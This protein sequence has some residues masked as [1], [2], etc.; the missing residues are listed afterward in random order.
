[1]LGCGATARVP[2][3]YEYE[4]AWT[5]TQECTVRGDSA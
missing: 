5:S 4:Y 2:D 1:L 3:E